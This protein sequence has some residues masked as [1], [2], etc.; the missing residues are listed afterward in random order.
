MPA[1][2]AVLLGVTAFAWLYWRGLLRVWARAGR[3]HAV[4]L[5]QAL[6]YTTGLATI[7]VALE[8][9]VDRLSADLFTAHMS[10][11]L[12]LILVAAPLI[13]LGAPLAPLVWGLPPA[14]RRAVGRA[15]HRV[16]PLSGVALAFPLHSLALWIWHL[17]PLYEAAFHSRGMHVLEHLSFL[18]TAILFWWAIRLPSGTGLVAVFALAGESTVL[19]ALLT[20]ADV[21]W[22]S[23]HLA[24][25]SR[26]GLTPLEDQQIAGLVMWIPGGVLY[27]GSGLAMLAAWFKRSS[28]GDDTLDREA[29]TSVG[30]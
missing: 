6:L 30:R 8:S 2:P 14:S 5:R 11:H 4:T 29:R 24:T 10:Q 12:L 18:L 13:V 1:E 17:P 27:L 20:F 3:G 22:Y 25:T 21:P 7:V 19:G 26:W 9:P 16:S 28:W 15:M 23:A